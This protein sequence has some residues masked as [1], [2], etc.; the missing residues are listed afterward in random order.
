MGRRWVR[1]AAWGT[2]A[3]LLA[4]FALGLLL[5]QT[6][7][8][9]RFAERQLRK[10]LTG[11]GA[12]FTVE[13]RSGTLLSGLDLWGVRITL[14][15]GGTVEAD[16]VSLRLQSTPLLVGIF[17]VKKPRVEGLRIALPP[18]SPS[19]SPDGEGSRSGNPL[20]AWLVVNVADLALDGRLALPPEKA[21]Q[22]GRVVAFTCAGDLF[23]AGKRLTLQHFEATVRPGEGL[24]ETVRLSGRLGFLPPG[25]VWGD[26]RME[27]GESRLRLAGKAERAGGRSVGEVRFEA[28]PV[29]LREAPLLFAGFPSLVLEGRGRAGWKGGEISWTFDGRERSAGPFRLGAR[30]RTSDAAVEV[31]GTLHTPGLSLSFLWSTPPGREPLL[32][33]SADFR[34]SV[35]GEG[36]RA[37]WSLTGRLGPSSVWGLPLTSARA[38]ASGG[39]ASFRIEGEGESPLLGH[40]PVSVEVAEGGNRVQLELAGD[41]VDLKALLSRLDL[42]P[43]LPEPLHLPVQPLSAERAR[44]LWQGEDFRLEAA[45]KDREGGAYAV[46]LDLPGRREPS[47][48]VQAEGISTGVWG[49]PGEG[50]LAFGARFRGRDLEH[51]V[52]ALSARRAN[53][54]GAE[55]APFEA[56]VDLDRWERFRVNRL[57]ADT[58]L[59]RLSLKDLSAGPGDALSFGWSFAAPSLEPLGRWLGL[60]LGGSLQA[61]GTLAGSFSRPRLLARFQGRDVQGA[62][63]TADALQGDAD[64]SPAARRVSLSW[65]GLSLSAGSL[66]DGE[67]V[68]RREGGEDRIEIRAQVGENRRIE[69]AARGTVGREA[70]DLVLDRAVVFL[71]ERPFA[72]ESPARVVWNAAEVSWRDLSLRR[73]ENRLTLSGKVERA[74]P[75]AGRIE[76]EVTAVHFPLRFF[77]LVRDPGRVQGH[78]DGTVRWRGTLEKPVLE[79]ALSF[80]GVRFTLPESDLVLL[81]EGRLKAAEDRLRFEEVK[82]TTPEGGAARLEGE[83]EFKGFLVRRIALRARGEDFPFVLFRDLT[84]MADFDLMLEGPPAAPVLSGKARILKGRIQLPDVARLSPLP[85]SLRFVNAPKGS[86]Y[87]EPDLEQDFL[88]RIRGSLGVSTETKFW[89][90]NRS[91]LAELSGN[92][93]LAF[94]PGGQTL[95]GTLQ[96]LS[97]RY[98]FQGLKFDLTDSRIHFKGTTDWT[99]ILDLTAR[100]QAPGAE[101]TARVQGSADHPTLTLSS[102][103][104]MEQ[105]DIL[106]TLLFGRS[107]NLSEGENAQWGSAAAALAFQY[108]AGG[109]LESVQHRLN[110]DSFSL[111][112]DPLG[113]P[114]VGFSKYIGDRTVL[115][116]YQTFGALPEGRLNLRY[117]INRNLSVQSESSTLGRSGVDL[118]WERRY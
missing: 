117:R 91:I 73:N 81:F 93:T 50:R 39:L 86:P 41:A 32:A 55:V 61:V 111:G 18:P 37:D 77:A 31:E 109:L 40:G 58:S 118:L 113:G 14:P 101:V 107:R 102:S 96:I 1:I 33:G 100:R 72:L 20:P 89:A 51:G 70:G 6:P 12:G 46:T 88:S 29:V 105:G 30:S 66:G 116:Y 44:L 22:A 94:T 115:E 63:F 13:S 78:A 110:V 87:A 43:A 67:G 114:Q 36:D 90:V 83:L 53:Y 16:R 54:L 21:G 15:G 64:L 95:S 28:A 26:L 25:E 45:G 80:S 10:A 8:L 24:P 48:E 99:P 60:P 47:W 27:G 76:G 112:A 92:L 2:V 84:G 82:V 9:D 34:L 49:I 85:P 59:G 68:L 65:K 35:P 7:L 57:E 42:L 19:P 62:G 5:R 79:G 74:G 56:E 17:Y 38:R 103:P 108:R 3:L 69:A 98:L 71:E 75:S 23:V 104:P 11:S 106:A 52:I 4:L 97:G